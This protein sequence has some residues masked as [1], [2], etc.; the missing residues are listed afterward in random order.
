MNRMKRRQLSLAVAKALGAGAIVGL[1]APV[2]YAQQ[3][4]PVEKV[5]KIEVTGSRIPLQTLESE[6]P[7]QI[8]TQ[9]DIKMTGLSN[10]S[11][12]LNQMPQVFAEIGQMEAN[13]ATGTA[14]LN[15]RGLGSSRTLVLID[16]KRLPA[17]DPRTP[18]TDINAIP[19]ALIQ[20][21]DILTG[22]ASAVYGS[23]AVA[24]VVNFIM[25]DHFEGV[26]FNYNANG[27][28]HH[29]HDSSGASAAVA[30]RQ[31]LNPSQFQ[32]P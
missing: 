26:Q 22:G 10:V 29:Q 6:S 24:G 11:D 25:N 18:S 19:A 15:L 23:D 12:I 14:T 4:A 5:Q 21:I 17:G 28:Q 31:V 8:I 32:V 2:A 30:A 3:Q 1:A 20:R 27:Y 16:G 7:V 13:G 9:Q